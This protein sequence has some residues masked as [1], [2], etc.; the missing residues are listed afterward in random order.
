MSRNDRQEK[1]VYNAS[2]LAADAMCTEGGAP[3]LPRA[4]ACRLCPVLSEP[5]H[6]EPVTVD[7]GGRRQ[8]G[9]TVMKSD[10][11]TH[12]PCRCGG[13]NPNC[14][15]CG[16]KGVI[17]GSGFRPIMAGPAGIRKRPFVPRDT[18]A[19]ISGPPAPVRCPHCNFEVLN[20]AVHLAE[21]HPD[22]PQGETPAEREANAARL[23]DLRP[24]VADVT[25]EAYVV[26]KR[27]AA[28]ISDALGGCRP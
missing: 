20:L 4:V 17:D 15:Q 21:D 25:I 24:D 9:L 18:G 3:G 2:T 16:G 8:E 14:P 6:V 13:A 27:S 12:R 1:D 28:E 5:E 7:R 19:T 10:H 23:A 11:P 26:S 22:Q